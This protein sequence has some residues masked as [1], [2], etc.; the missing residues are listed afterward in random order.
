MSPDANTLEKSSL[1]DEILF[2]LRATGGDTL[3]GIL[4]SVL[5][6]RIMSQERHMRQAVADLVCTGKLDE[7]QVGNKVLYR[8]RN[9]VDRCG[10]CS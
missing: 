3:D 4:W 6:K 7:V 10:R 1:Y 9:P 5:D 2:H 8:L